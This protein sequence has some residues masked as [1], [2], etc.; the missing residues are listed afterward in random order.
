MATNFCKKI[1]SYL[2]VPIK[3]IS[4]FGTYDGDWLGRCCAKPEIPP[5]KKVLHSLIYIR[6]L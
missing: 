6:G 3:M 1:K 5:E 4:I 2:H